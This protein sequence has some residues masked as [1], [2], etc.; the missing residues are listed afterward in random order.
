[1]VKALRYVLTKAPGIEWVAGGIDLSLNDDTQKGGNTGWLPQFYG[2]VRTTNITPLTNLLRK[3]YP[4]TD[5]SPRPVQIKLFKGEIEAFSYAF[6]PVFTKRIAY[7]DPQG[8]WNT[9]KVYLPP[10]DHVQAMLW[11]H[12]TG[13]SSRL[14]FKNVRMTRVGQHIELVK[15]RQLK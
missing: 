1:M 3:R 10:R 13:F 2:F 7:I 9:R 4:K 12:N 14:F 6:K 5:K 8:R 15:V 11:M